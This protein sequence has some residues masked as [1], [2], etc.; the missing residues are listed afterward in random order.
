MDASVKQTLCHNGHLDLVF[1]F[2]FFLLVDSQS[3][4]HLS[5]VDM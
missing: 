1:A 5:N 4:E 3:V 2:L